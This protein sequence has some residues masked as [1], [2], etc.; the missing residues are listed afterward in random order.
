MEDIGGPDISNITTIQCGDSYRPGQAYTV[1]L[2]TVGGSFTDFFTIPNQGTGGNV[3]EIVI[4]DDGGALLATGVDGIRFNFADTGV[5]WTVNRE[6]DVMGTATTPEPAT[7]IM[8][9][10][11]LPAL[12]KRRRSRS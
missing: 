11:G 9:A 2:R 6:L 7:M 1:W 10:A 8:L 4:A 12:M 5:G 3:H